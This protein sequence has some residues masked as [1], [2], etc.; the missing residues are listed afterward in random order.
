MKIRSL[1]KVAI[2]AGAAMA[3]AVLPISPA[4]AHSPHPIVGIA[5]S[6]SGEVALGDSVLVTATISDQHTLAPYTT[7]NVEL[8]YKQGGSTYYTFASGTPNSSGVFAD[9]LDVTSPPF[10]LTVGDDGEP[11][12]DDDKELNLRV[13]Y[14]GATTAQSSVLVLDVVESAGCDD[15][16]VHISE[17]SVTGT[18]VPAPGSTER[19]TFAIEVRNCTGVD[20]TGVKVQGGTSGWTSLD[21]TPSASKAPVP[22]VKTN[23]KT[24]IITWTG[25]LADGEAVTITVPVTGTVGR[26]CGAIQYLSGAWSAAY[27]ITEPGTPPVTT[28]YKTDYTGRASVEVTCAE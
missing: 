10:V 26:I 1:A 21:G 23:K 20:L 9:T 5:A 19:W 12:T 7:G 17:P 2:L 24:S 6:P 13:L 28:K 16:T 8:Q 15:G 11:D 22:S 14:D 3:V 4:S 25:D 18:G 27:Q